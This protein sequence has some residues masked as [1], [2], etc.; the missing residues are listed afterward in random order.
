MEYIT[1]GEL[2]SNLEIFH[3][4]KRI[5]HSTLTKKWFKSDVIKVYNSENSLLVEIKIKPFTN[6]YILSYIN[7]NLL[8][9]KLF[10]KNSKK[11]IVNDK[12]TFN[13]IKNCIP[14]KSNILLN[15]KE[16]AKVETKLL[17]FNHNH[18]I[19]FSNENK[20]HIKYS[21]ILFLI[22]NTFLDLE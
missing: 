17:S 1:K 22:S 18:K 9:G 3:K 13:Y 7:N 6:E 14:Y 16:I 12:L 10:L 15:Q 21:L 20:E 5:Y 11:I 4:S 19:T 8:N 2:N